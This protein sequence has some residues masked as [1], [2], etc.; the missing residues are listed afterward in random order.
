MS[1]SKIS[2]APAT[3][4]NQWNARNRTG[5]EHW[6]VS[7]TGTLSA[8]TDAASALGEVGVKP[9][10][11]PRLSLMHV[12]NIGSAALNLCAQAVGKI[13]KRDIPVSD[14]EW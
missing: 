6:F 5:S 8:V 2:P 3:L 10:L 13:I 14:E 11:S 1:P 7:I 4:R 9:F 12:L